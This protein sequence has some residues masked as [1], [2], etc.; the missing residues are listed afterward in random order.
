MKMPLQNKTFAKSI[1]GDFE[2]CY[3]IF[4]PEFSRNIL[5]VSLRYDIIF[6][7]E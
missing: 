6:Y 2:M 1:V 7:C 3:S 4:T 5:L